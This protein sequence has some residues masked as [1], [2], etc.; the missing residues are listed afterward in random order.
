MENKITS[1]LLDLVAQRYRTIGFRNDFRNYLINYLIKK[2]EWDEIYALIISKQIWES[3]Y[4]NG[5][6]SLAKLWQ[7]WG[8]RKPSVESKE[9]REALISLI[10]YEQPDWLYK[11]FK[12][13]HDFFEK[14]K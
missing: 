2:F 1:E 12:D 13:Y 10:N 9:I 7:Q 14:N 3:Y 5:S 4:N 6:E 11:N 8:L